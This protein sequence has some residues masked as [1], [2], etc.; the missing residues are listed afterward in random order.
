[1]SAAS[2]SQD[3]RSYVADYIGRHPEDVISLDDVDAEDDYRIC[4]LAFELERHG[5]YPM[6]RR[7]P[8]R[9]NSSTI[10][11]NVFASRRRLAD[12]FGVDVESIHR[13]FQSAARG[14]R[15]MREVSSG[16]VCETVRE[17]DQV[18]LRELPA[19][20]HFPE[21]RGAYLTSAILVAE[22]PDTGV[23]NLSYHRCV[24]HSPT[25]LATSLHSRRHLW[26]MLRR[27]EER[28]RVLPVAVVIG[29]HPL[30]MLAAAARVGPEVDER[31]IAGGLFGSPL[32]VVR[33]PRHQIGVPAGSEFVLEGHI[34]PK[35]HVDEGP[36]GEFTG[37]YSNRST[38]NVI[39]VETQL[40]RT[41]PM[42]LDVVGGRSSDHLTLSRLP[43]E[44]ELVEALLQRFP[45]ITG[46]HYPSSGTHFHCYVALRPQLAGEARQVIL[47]LLGWDPYLKLVVA[48]DD[49]IDVESDAEVLWAVATRSQSSRDLLSADGLPGMLLDPSSASDGTTSRMGIDATRAPEFSGHT[50]DPDP[51]ATAWAR[52]F[53]ESSDPEARRA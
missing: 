52:N 6:I 21:D 2:T 7:G 1:M 44:A 41:D 10:V 24:A 4:A 25:E 53:V 36:F 46:I 30:F 28:G 17:A 22:D 35:R 15:P 27:A 51:S 29:G 3:L 14:A 12:L 26:S 42:L 39:T 47:A 37:Y 40:Q 16:P 11:T 33:T 19:I 9:R 34:D 5:R 43:R 8:T 49:D 45:A 23:G 18:D 38:N 13:E 31:E 20:R 32:E 50:A 48:V